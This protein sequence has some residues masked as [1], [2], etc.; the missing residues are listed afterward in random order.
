[1]VGSFNKIEVCT[2]RVCREKY[3]LT[4]LAVEEYWG[5]T[6]KATSLDDMKSQSNG[7]FL[8]RV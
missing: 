4:T 5:K 6:T 2:K 1:M 8:A 7:K 3:G